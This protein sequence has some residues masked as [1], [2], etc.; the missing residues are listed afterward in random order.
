MLNPE[1]LAEIDDEEE[2]QDILERYN[3]IK[4]FETFFMFYCGYAGR[5]VNSMQEIKDFIGFMINKEEESD[6]RILQLTKIL[7]T[8]NENMQENFINSE[9]LE[10]QELLLKRAEQFRENN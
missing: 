1:R 6:G 7:K 10:R 4:R 3:D 5:P 2:I 8:V 9:G